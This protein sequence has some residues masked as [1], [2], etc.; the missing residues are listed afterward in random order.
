MYFKQK[1]ISYDVYFLIYF[2]PRPKAA[3][4][5]NIYDMIYILR[6]EGAP[7]LKMSKIYMKWNI[8]RA[9]KARGNFLGIFV[10]KIYIILIYFLKNLHHMIYIFEK[11]IR[12][13]H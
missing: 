12:S 2:Y 11:Y 4:A 8:F 5:K 7:A 1:Y 9:P 13:V 3:A 10:G 6:A